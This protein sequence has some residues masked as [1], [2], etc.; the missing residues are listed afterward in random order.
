VLCPTRELAVQVASECTRLMR[1]KRGISVLPVYGGQ[2]IDRQIEALHRGV[3]IVVGTPGRLL[4]HLERRTISFHAVTMVVLDEAD[5]MLDMGFSEPINMILEKVPNKPQMA[6]FSATIPP[7][8][9]TM[10]SKYM[11]DPLSVGDGNRT[12]TVAATQQC[13]LDVDHYQKTDILCRVLDIHSVKRGI[14]FCNT[15]KMV[16][17]LVAELQTRG[18]AADALHGDLVQK[19]RDRVMASF[20]KGGIQ[21]LVATD[22]AGRGIDVEDID[23]VIN[24]DLP[25]DEEDY[26]HRIGRTSRAGKS[27]A[28]ISLVCG[29]DIYK[30]QSIERF[31]RVRI[32]R[33]KTPTFEDARESTTS[34]LYKTIRATIAA[35]HLAPYISMVETACGDNHTP[36]DIAAALLKMHSPIPKPSAEPPRR[37]ERVMTRADRS[38]R[39]R[40]RRG[41]GRT[42]PTYF[43][44]HPKKHFRKK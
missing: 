29:R 12:L 31:A 39:E 36:M 41:A 10:I 16:D 6:F 23:Y 26:V 35:G 32:E 20:R 5:E 22:V 7:T 19:M 27:G 14:V 33:R 13:Y 18:Y 24:Y 43:Q 25:Q 11:V 34:R 40:T 15:K 17:D 37:P 3:H 2:P 28:A 21:V 44:E 9:R 30:L 38:E 1:H 4:D 42:R 8:I